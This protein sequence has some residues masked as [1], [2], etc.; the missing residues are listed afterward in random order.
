MVPARCC[1]SVKDTLK[2]KL[3]SPSA[4]EAQGKLQPMRRRYPSSLGRGARDTAVNATP[5]FS[6]CT[7]M[8]SKP[9]AMAEHDGQPWVPA[10]AKHEVVD[11]QLR[12]AAEQ[13]PQRRLALFG[14]EGI[15]ARNSH[16]GQRLALARDFIA[17]PGEFF[18]G[19]QQVET[20]LEPL[21]TG[22]YGVGHRLLLQWCFSR[23]RISRYAH[24][25]SSNGFSSRRIC[26]FSAAPTIT[27]KYVCS[28]LPWRSAKGH[29]RLA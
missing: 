8:P 10:G 1:S 21:I 16:P 6:R 5:W 27:M 26:A 22:A 4:A 19:L 25:A 3:N 14:V 12:T 13:V 9:S 15:V 2:S 17:A 11:Q 7:A 28:A 20:G 23:Q 18:L 29:E 24:S